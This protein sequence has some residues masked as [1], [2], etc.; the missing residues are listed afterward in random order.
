MAKKEPV[1]ITAAKISSKSSLIGN[2]FL[3]LV[4]LIGAILVFITTPFGQNI[5]FPATMT[6]T[7]ALATLPFVNQPTESSIVAVQT[8]DILLPTSTWTPIP[9][10]TPLVTTT[11]FEDTFIDNRNNWD[12][13]SGFPN[14]AAGKYKYKSDCPSSY[15]EFFCGTYIRVPF[16]F[17]KNF[18][19]GID[20]TILD[21][22][23]D[24]KIALGFQVRRRNSN[25]YYINYFITDMFYVMKAA[26]HK[27][28]LEIIPKTSTSLMSADLEST[29]RFG[30]EL[31][32]AIFTPVINDNRLPQA[33]DG[34]M[35]NA[36]DTYLVVFVSR[37]Y[38]ATIQF[39]NLVVQEVK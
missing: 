18:H 10:F 4:A 27:S 32:D 36:G 19:M 35:Q 21:S 20:F 13:G 22:S 15:S 30:I 17:P 14:I 37:G 23:P 28:D 6:P 39:D 16:T 7:L 8:D 1:T 9:S 38:S 12:I 33:E 5:I 26:Y 2:L 3:G 29:N 31:Q 25:L 11:I 24:A 34:N